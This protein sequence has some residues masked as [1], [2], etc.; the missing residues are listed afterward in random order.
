[1]PIQSLHYYVNGSLYMMT[2]YKYL[3]EIAED[4]VKAKKAPD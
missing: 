2:V 4:F 3:I 1:M